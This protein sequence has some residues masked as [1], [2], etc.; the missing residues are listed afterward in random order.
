MDHPAAHPLRLTAGEIAAAAGGRVIAGDPDTRFSGLAIDSRAVEPGS[1]FIALPGARVDGHDFIPQALAR[2]AAGVL[3]SRGEPVAGA[4]VTIAVDETLAALQG[5][6]REWRSRLRA[7][8]IGIAGSNGKTTTK[9]VVASVLAVRGRTFATP[10]NEN[11]QVGTPMAILAAPPD[12]EFLVLELGTSAAGELGR[13]ASFARPDLAIVTAAFAEHLEF[14]GSLDGVIA[15]EA[16][17][18]D[19]LRPGALALVGSAEPRL[20]AAAR[21]RAGLRVAAVGRRDEDAWRIGAVRM[22]RDGTRFE[23]AEGL[24]A[25]SG[26][27]W[28][29]PLLGE[30][31]AW[32]A[33]FAVAVAREL[34]LSNDEIERGLARAH[35]AAH[36]MV[37]IGH[38][39]RPLFV[40]DDCYNSNPASARAAIEATIAL[41]APV[42]RVIL[43][44]GDML[45]LGDESASAHRELG[46]EVARTAPRAHLVAVG[47]AAA[48]TAAT[49]RSRGVSTDAVADA[50]R[51]LERVLEVVAADGGAPTVVLVKGSRGVALERVVAGLVA[52]AP[53]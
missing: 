37:P 45:E 48:E 2:R 13:L 11:S 4:A 47:P 15:A 16:E 19:H 31:A 9:E 50:A 26:H 49:A 28:H 10:G 38:P 34:G 21:Q 29:V 51:A 22:A 20:V 32:A 7:T 14:L 43:V 33:S 36:R 41:A 6:A 5:A 42:E 3:S 8:V 23:L 18:L 46:E 44:L 39:S 25:G 27:T 53:G 30:P 1:L 24:P 35:P 52:L 17:I 40:I 12:T